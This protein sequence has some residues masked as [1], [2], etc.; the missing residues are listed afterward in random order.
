MNGVFGVPTS[1]G[2]GHSLSLGFRLKWAS[3]VVVNGS[4]KSDQL[5]TCSFAANGG[6]LIAG[7]TG[8]ERVAADHNRDR[9]PASPSFIV[10]LMGLQHFHR[11]RSKCFTLI[12]LLVVIAIIA[13]LAAM[14]L[15]A[16]RGAKESAKSATCVNN[17]RQVY[18][19]FA[20]YAADNTQR[21]P[22]SD[23]WYYLAAYFG[24]GDYKCPQGV[25]STHYRILQCPGEKGHVLYDIPSPT[26]V[27]KM[28]DSPWGPSSYMIN[29]FL[30]NWPGYTSTT[31]LF[32]EN[33]S[34]PTGGG[35]GPFQVYS[36]SQVNFLMDCG[37]WDNGWPPPFFADDIDDD[38][39]AWYGPRHVYSYAFRHPGNRANV[40]YY[41]GH[42]ASVLPWTQSG[43]HVFTWKYP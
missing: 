40:L 12:E 34:N 32:G 7:H 20:L 30:A 35:W 4:Y 5:T 24:P 19:A 17:L 27:Y 2:F 11:R 39:S 38:P 22:P 18:A 41:D 25:C 31:P 28:Y 23:Y 10:N 21:V 42:V 16:L 9:L 8:A 33:T 26:T 6:F 14:L 43:Q 15:P 36:A 3:N 29:L 1:V 13:V 37:V